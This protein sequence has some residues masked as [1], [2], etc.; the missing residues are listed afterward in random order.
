MPDKE[1]E[2]CIKTLVQ[3]LNDMEIPTLESCEGH[4]SPERPSYPYVSI[5]LEPPISGIS[6]RILFLLSLFT[7][8]W[9]GYYPKEDGWILRPNCYRN[10]EQ[11]GYGPYFLT[12]EPLEKNNQ[13]DPQI[14]Q[15]YQE[16]A[17]GFADFLKRKWETI[18]HLENIL[19]DLERETKG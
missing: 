15:K 2:P 16:R 11:R 7:A 10:S 14:L 5:V 19:E 3:A 9:N 8:E 1:F 17:D 13:R 12:L 6:P 4:I 18:K